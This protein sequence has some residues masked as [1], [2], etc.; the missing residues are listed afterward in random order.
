[1]LFPF[2]HGLSYTQF[3][4]SDAALLADWSADSETVE[5]AVTVTNS[6][7][8][9]GAEVVQLYVRDVEATAYR[10]DRELKAFQKISLAAGESRQV[11][12][13]LDKR[14]FAYFDVTQ[15]DW[16]VEPG[17]FEILFAAS[18]TDIRQTLTV[19]LPDGSGRNSQPMREAHVIMEDTQLAALGLTVTA[20]EA[21]SL[22][23]NTTWPI[24]AATGSASACVRRRSIWRPRRWA[25]GK[26]R[27]W[28]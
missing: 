1:M 22:S 20:P 11:Q 14:A 28:R 10:P 8:K 15:D 5:V 12:F 26:K 21:S 9:A 13:T 27:R 7:D 23:A 4:Y 3:S 2:G 25:K 16:D 18:C 6:G 19:N 17:A 24:F